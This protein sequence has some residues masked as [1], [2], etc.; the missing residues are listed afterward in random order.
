VTAT[1]S[2]CPSGKTCSGSAQ[3]FSSAN[4]GICQ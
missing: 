1:P 2:G 4:I 3:L